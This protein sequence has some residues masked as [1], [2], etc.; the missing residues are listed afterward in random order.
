[1][2]AKDLI[3]LSQTDEARSKNFKPIVQGMLSDTEKLIGKLEK[4]DGIL[5]TSAKKAYEDAHWQLLDVKKHLQS[6][7]SQLSGGQ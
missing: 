3:D 2:K 1:M 7:L 5:K 4:N 6:A